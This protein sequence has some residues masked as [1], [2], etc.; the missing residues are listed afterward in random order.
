MYTINTN[1]SDIIELENAN[2]SSYAKIH[3]NLGA[4]LQELTLNKHTIIEDLS[5]LSYSNTYASSILFPFANRI[6]DGIYSFEGNQYQFDVNEIGNN[7]ALHG[8][9]FNKTFKIKEQNATDTFASV[10]LIYVEKNESKG[11]PYTYTIHLKYTLTETGLDLK[12]LVTN[13]DTKPFPFTLGWHPYFSSSDLFNS[14]LNF[15]S[16]TQLVFDDKC[17]TTGTKTIENEPIFE[18]KDK[19]LDDCFILNNNQIQFNTPNYKLQIASSSNENFLQIYTPPKANVIAIEP[20]TGVSDSFNNNM[21]L[22][23]LEPDNSYL[24]NWTLKLI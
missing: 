23:I 22:Q 5:P 24:V 14:T 9:V 20:T 8:L 3:L 1:F 10:T 15:D 21:G 19:K 12:V 13:T 4:S 17:I 2:K 11:F 7:N 6:K 16:D 18:I